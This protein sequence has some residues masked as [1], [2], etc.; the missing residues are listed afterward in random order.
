MEGVRVS[1]GAML[2]PP[3][4]SPPCSHWA[5]LT[6]PRDV[7]AAPSHGGMWEGVS[8]PSL[9]VPG[10]LQDPG[11]PTAQP[12]LPRSQKCPG[13]RWGFMPYSVPLPASSPKTPKPPEPNPPTT[14]GVPSPLTFQPLV[15]FWEHSSC[16]LSPG[17]P[18]LLQH[19]ANPAAP[20]R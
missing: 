4:S 3:P 15:P 10:L 6:E 14:P 1:D 9:G 11:L 16:L 19:N 8:A 13:P 2:C 17:F 20:F 5:K 18:V 12:Y 7:S